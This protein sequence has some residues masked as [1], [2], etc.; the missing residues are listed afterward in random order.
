MS[1]LVV[2]NDEIRKLGREPGVVKNLDANAQDVRRRVLVPRHLTLSTRAGIG[3]RDA[4][5]QV[6]MRG[7]GAIAYEFGGRTI[8]A[9]AP[10][11]RAIASMQ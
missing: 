11:R 2:H 6:I 5:S 4:F 8:S 7:P 9:R 10:L 1:R 3:P